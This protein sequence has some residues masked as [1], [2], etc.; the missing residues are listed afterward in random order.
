MFAHPTNSQQF[1]VLFDALLGAYMADQYWGRYLTIQISIGIA[2][3]GHT[4]LI[5]AAIPAVVVSPNAAIAVFSIAILI[6]GV[7]TVKL[8]RSRCAVSD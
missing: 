4:F 3:V 6:M 2:L 8:P 5:I 7:G 1:L